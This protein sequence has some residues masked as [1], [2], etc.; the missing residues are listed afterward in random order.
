M[1]YYVKGKRAY[2]GAG[3]VHRWLRIRSIG[4]DGNRVAISFLLAGQEKFMSLTY[5]PQQHLD[6]GEGTWPNIDTVDWE[7]ILE[8]E[9]YGS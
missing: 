2:R 8:E 5:G 4:K 6:F 3:D 1:T 9:G 7:Y